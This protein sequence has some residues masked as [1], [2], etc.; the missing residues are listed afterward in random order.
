RPLLLAV[1]GESLLTAAAG[2][3]V[4]TTVGLF[5]GSV[6]AAGYYPGGV[7][8]VQ[9]DILFIAVALIL[10]TAAAVTAAPALAVARTAPAEA[11]RLID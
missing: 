9:T 2:I 7:I 3:V 5:V 4:G 6:I 8:R 10:I 11:L 1:M